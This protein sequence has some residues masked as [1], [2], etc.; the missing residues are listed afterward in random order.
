MTTNRDV[1]QAPPDRMTVFGYEQDSGADFP[2]KSLR[3]SPH[4]NAD[5]VGADHQRGWRDQ[6][7]LPHQRR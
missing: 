4:R 1:A 2:K 7:A 6:Y 3:L 5:G